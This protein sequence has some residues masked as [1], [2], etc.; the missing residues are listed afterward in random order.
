MYPEHV[1]AAVD[2]AEPD[3]EAGAGTDGT[4][5]V[6]DPAEHPDCTP[7]ERCGSFG[8]QIIAARYAADF[9]CLIYAATRR[10]QRQI[11]EKWEIALDHRFNCAGIPRFNFA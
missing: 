2:P 5:C 11:P 10:I 8:Y 1:S 3:E 7:I 4:R 6:R 9:H